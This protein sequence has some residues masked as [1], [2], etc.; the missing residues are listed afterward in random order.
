MEPRQLRA[1]CISGEI[2][3]VCDGMSMSRYAFPPDD[4]VSRRIR[5]ADVSWPRQFRALKAGNN[6]GALDGSL[7]L[8]IAFVRDVDGHKLR[9]TRFYI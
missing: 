6:C 8:I 1:R 7:A 9:L 2:P 3:I 5:P 4:C